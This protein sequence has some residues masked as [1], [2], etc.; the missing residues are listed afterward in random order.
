MILSDISGAGHMV[1]GDS[2]TVY[3]SGIFT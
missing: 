2:L 3:S 1:H